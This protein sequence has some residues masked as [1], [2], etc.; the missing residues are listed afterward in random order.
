M[1]A[2]VATLAFL[3]TIWLAL[4]VG[5]LMLTGNRSKILAA[6]KGQSLLATQQQFVP[7][8]RLSQRSRQPRPLRARPKLRAAA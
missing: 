7:A 8:V 3:T 6:L 2:A 4:L 1:L 5:A